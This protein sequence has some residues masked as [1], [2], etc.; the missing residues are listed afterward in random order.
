MLVSFW[1]VAVSCYATDVNNVRVWIAPDH[2]RLVFDLSG[3]VQHKLFTLKKPDRIVLDL[4]G[5]KLLSDLSVVDLSKSPVSLMRS[6][7]RN[8]GKD[9]RVVL[10]L[11]ETVKPK[12]FA[13]KPNDQYGHRL[14]LDLYREVSEE[15]PQK[16]A[17]ASAD[18]PATLRDIIIAIDAGHG[19]EDPGAIGPGRVKE[20]TVVLGIARELKALL[21][22]ERGFKPKLTR[23]GDYYISLRSRTQRARK[24]N[25]DMFVSIHADGFKDKRAKGA[26]VWVLSPRGASSE[27][28]RWLAR[29]ENSADLIGGVGS[30]SLEDKDDVLAKV[31]LDMSMTASRS[32]S[33]QIA[34]SIHR[35]LGRFAKM[36]KKQVEQAGFVVLKSPDIPSILVETGFI[37]NHD[38]AAKLKSKA[39]QRKM[40]QAIFAGIK[41]HFTNKPPALTWLAWQKNGQRN[42]KSMSSSYKVMRG[43]TLSV[44]ASRNGV[45]LTALRKVNGLRNADHI[46]IGQVLKIPAS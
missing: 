43:D 31:L 30:V 2:A 18:N 19:G 20:K 16:T 25:A 1:L 5:A 45:S 6:G 3:A 27:M 46:Q 10:D 28:G 21:A 8:G 9:L 17:I 40:A 11:K 22:K 23:D 36:H 15:V 41:A 33:R 35:N 44:I 38:E 42:A 34:H 29:K 24:M 37:T 26:S 12:S 4:S 32:D 39:Y 13:L 7:S 14:V